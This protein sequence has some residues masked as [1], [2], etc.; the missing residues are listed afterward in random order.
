LQRKKRVYHFDTRTKD[1]IKIKNL[2]DEDFVVCGYIK[3]ENNIVSIILGQYSNNELIYKGHVTLEITSN[4]FEIISNTK[5]IDYPYFK[6][7]PTG[8]ENAIWLEPILAC[9][10]KYMMKSPSRYNASASI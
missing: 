9:T 5:I 1:W 3:K 10:V 7:I 4:D 2:L 6:T 8:N